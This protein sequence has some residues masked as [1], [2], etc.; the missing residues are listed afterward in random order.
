MVSAR[1]MDIKQFV[2]F[3]WLPFLAADLGCVLSGYLSPFLARRFRISLANSRIAGIGLRAV[4]MVG[5]GLIGLAQSPFAAICLFSLGAFAHQM[6]SSLLYAVVTDNFEP[7]EVATATGFGGMA[8]YLGGTLFSLLIGQLA[9]RIG[10]EPLFACLTVFELVAL[11]V[12][13]LMLGERRRARPLPD[14]VA[15]H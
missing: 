15:A 12:V 13:W 4:C 6:V 2:L 8:G 1:G 9:G 5:P 7:C 14:G 10:Y 3:A 11:L